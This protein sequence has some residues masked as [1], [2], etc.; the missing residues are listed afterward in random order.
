M[1]DNMYTEG[2]CS[3]GAAVLCDGVRLTISE[4]LCRLNKLAKLEE[5]QH[6]TQQTEVQICRFDG[7]C[8]SQSYVSS[9]VYCTNNDECD[10]KH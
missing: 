1:S 8:G 4:I 3:D 5:A 10:D 6:S 9:L 2:V 7:K